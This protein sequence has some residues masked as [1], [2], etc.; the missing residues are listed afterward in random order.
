MSDRVVPSSRSGEGKIE[1]LA[2]EDR[3]EGASSAIN[4]AALTAR[5]LEAVGL[6]QSRA[7]QP[8]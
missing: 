2:S 8:T 5:I 3:H 1:R 6:N 4:E 7:N